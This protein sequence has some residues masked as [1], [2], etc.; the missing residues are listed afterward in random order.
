MFDQAD[1]FRITSSA[2]FKD[3]AARAAGVMLVDC[4]EASIAE[5]VYQ[6]DL[7]GLSAHVSFEGPEAS[8][9]PLQDSITGYL[10]SCSR[11]S[12]H[13]QFLWRKKIPHP[14]VAPH[15]SACMLRIVLY[16]DSTVRSWLRATKY[17]HVLDG[18]APEGTWLHSESTHDH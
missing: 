2:L 15:E 5:T 14:R 7:A 16:M 11:S 18:R 3:A 12:R 8:R 13:V 10:C 6:A 17:S 9:S 1:V 4:L